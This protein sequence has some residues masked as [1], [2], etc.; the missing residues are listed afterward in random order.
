MA[1][2]LFPPDRCVEKELDRQ[3]DRG[4]RFRAIERLSSRLESQTVPAD[5]ACLIM[6]RDV[7]DQNRSDD[8]SEFATNAVRE[9][10]GKVGT[11]A[12]W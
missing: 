8:G 6:N 2:V 3:F 11:I 7:P 5:V 4:R 9:L 1:R 12:F 10:I